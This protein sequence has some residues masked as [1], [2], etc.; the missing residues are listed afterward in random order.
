M[1]WFKAKDVVNEEV[2]ARP[3]IKIPTGDYSPKPTLEYINDA[4]IPFDMKVAAHI[5]EILSGFDRERI[6]WIID[7]VMILRG[8]R[9]ERDA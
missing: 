9:R 6:M 3:E 7:M 5:S 1:P 4:K 2:A 8:L